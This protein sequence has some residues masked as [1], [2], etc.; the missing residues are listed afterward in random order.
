MEGQS[1]PLIGLGGHHL[2]KIIPGHGLLL[3]ADLKTLGITKK[4]PGVIERT[5]FMRMRDALAGERGAITS[6][7]NVISA[8]R[9]Q[10]VA[11]NIFSCSIGAQ[12]V[13]QQYDNSNTVGGF[14]SNGNVAP[15][16]T[17]IAG[18]FNAN[19][20]DPSTG[21]KRYLIGIASMTGT[22]AAHG[23]GMGIYADFLTT[24]GNLA[25]D[26][27]TLQTFTIAAITRRT[28]GIG[29]YLYV[30][31]TSAG[32]TFPSAT[33]CTA[34]YTNSAGVAG[35]STTFA[36][37]TGTLSYESMM[38]DSSTTGNDLMAAPLAAG[39]FG[40]RSI[41]SLQLSQASST[42]GGKMGGAL[43]HPYLFLHGIPEPFVTVERDARAE[44][45]MLIEFDVDGSGVL[46]YHTMI[47]TNDAATVDATISFTFDT[48]EG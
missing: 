39:D 13:T 2:G 25:V 35:Q 29:V 45:E 28:S 48:C 47:W 44:P 1:H 19:A 31:A 11:T 37:G 36:V 38:M 41:A 18:A 10:Y 42:T 32:A 26:V 8:P 33:T 40:I 20:K 21:K 17:S 34:S 24:W 5:P 16:R 30:T 15:T 4:I 14:N 12:R 7:A 27:A 9:H 23:F 43:Y 46:G 3:P 6:L 22:S